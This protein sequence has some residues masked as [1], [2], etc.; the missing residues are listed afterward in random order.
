MQYSN[1]SS[2]KIL[3]RKL[4]KPY[5]NR[6]RTWNKTSYEN[7]T[8]KKN[9]GVLAT[10]ATLNGNKY[11]NLLETLS[12]EHDVKVH[13]QACTGLVE[14]IENG[15][16]NHPETVT[17]LQNWLKPMSVNSVDTIVL[18]CTH[19]PL[20]SEVIKEI[21]GANIILIETG[22]AIAKRLEDLSSL[23]GH[24]GNS[25]LKIKVFLYR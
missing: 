6:N 14:Q 7:N 3:K 11:Q 16:I 12:L 19:Y 22:T 10:P 23:N 13:E 15:K 25:E 18:G 9:V 21:M 17:M 24:N 1:F 8:I 5:S 2:N 4:S 20:I